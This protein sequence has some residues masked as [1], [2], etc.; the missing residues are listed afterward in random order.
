M[1]TPGGI[2]PHIHYARMT[3]EDE[4]RRLEEEERELDTAIAENEKLQGLREE[5]ERM[6]RRLQEVRYSDHWLG[7]GSDRRGRD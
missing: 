6:R 7:P 2:G 4:I 5:K 3:Q 1:A